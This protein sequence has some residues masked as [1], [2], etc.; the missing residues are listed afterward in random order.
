VASRSDA[1]LAVKNAQETGQATTLMYALLQAVVNDIRRGNYGAAQT[2]VDELVALADER[3][4]P[5]W[6][7]LG[8]AVGLAFYRYRKSLGCSSGDHLGDRLTSVNWSSAL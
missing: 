1:E 7:G 2:Q 6:K 5:F 4:T 8:T 3:G